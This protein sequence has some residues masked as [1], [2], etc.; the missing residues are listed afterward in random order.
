MGLSHALQFLNE[1]VLQIKPDYVFLCETICRKETVEKVRI[2]LDFEGMI[3]VEANGC[4]GGVALLWHNKDEVSLS[5]FNKNHIDVI[6]TTKEGSKYRL[7]GVY[8][9]PD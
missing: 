1:I 2:S 6:V 3:H 8:G 7:I 4:S 5:S 9:E